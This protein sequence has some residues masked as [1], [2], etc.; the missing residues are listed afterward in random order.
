MR[1]DRLYVHIPLTG[2]FMSF[3]APSFSSLTQIEKIFR[4][5]RREVMFSRFEL[6]HCCISAIYL[7]EVFEVVKWICAVPKVEIYLLRNT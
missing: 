1:D 4:Y 2:S 7:K 5:V 6:D 3:Y